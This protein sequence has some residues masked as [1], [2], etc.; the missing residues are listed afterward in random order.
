VTSDN[1]IAYVHVRADYRLNRQVALQTK[2]FV[3]GF[4]LALEDQ[5]LRCFTPAELRR[6]VSGDDADL[7]MEDLK[8][9][10]QYAGGYH[11]SHKVVQWLWQTVKEMAPEDQK[12]FLRYVTSCSKPPLSGFKSLNPAFTVRSVDSD[13]ATS[14]ASSAGIGP[15]TVVGTLSAFFGIGASSAANDTD[16]L[17]SASTCFNL[18]KLPVYKSKKHLKERLLYAIRSNAGFELS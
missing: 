3:N 17:P 13:P 11:G 2:A 7:D 4:S 18:L 16:R 8:R 14:A 12:L 10:A 9:H 5:W 1:K 6:L 15:P